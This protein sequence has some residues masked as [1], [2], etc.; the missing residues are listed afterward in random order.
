[1][2]KPSQQ[3]VTKVVVLTKK[4]IFFINALISRIPSFII[5]F[6]LHY[7]IFRLS[8]FSAFLIYYNLMA[9]KNVQR[10]NEVQYNENIVP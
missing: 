4:N 9:G 2:V 3:L 6:Y 5:L 8:D 7:Y 10:L 1:M